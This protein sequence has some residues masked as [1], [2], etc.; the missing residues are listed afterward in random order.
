[1]SYQA[2][3]KRN[4]N[5]EDKKQSKE[6]D[7]R[8][9]DNVPHFPTAVVI[10]LFVENNDSLHTARLRANCARER[11]WICFQI[12]AARNWFA[13]RLEQWRRLINLVFIGHPALH[14]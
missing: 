2:R 4:C 8:C 11:H 3:E 6:R 13:V 1:M 12:I 5:S 14:A 7:P 10:C 9:S